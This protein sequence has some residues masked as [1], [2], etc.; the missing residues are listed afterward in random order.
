[1]TRYR[2]ASALGT[3]LGFLLLFGATSP[4]AQG[5][6]HLLDSGPAASLSQILGRATDR[7][8]T[9][10]VLSAVGDEAYDEWSDR[11]GEDARKTTT[12]LLQPG[13]PTEIEIGGLQPNTRY[14][15]RLF[16]KGRS[17]ASFGPEA[18]CSFTRSGPRAAPSSSRCRGTP[19]RNGRGKCSMPKTY[20]HLNLDFR[21]S[22]GFHHCRTNLFK[23]CW[24]A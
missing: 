3:L 18:E 8:V 5:R 23:K 13:V 2:L 19:I 17:Q 4:E 21:R 10:S 6:K 22:S 14:F 12:V 9:L 20:L 15:Y 7:S 1:M 16:A 24:L 11:P